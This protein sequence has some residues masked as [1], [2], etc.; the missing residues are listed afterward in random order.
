MLLVAFDTV[1]QL[2]YIA[3]CVKPF[4]PHIVSQPTG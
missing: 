1:L 2:C 3:P 4:L